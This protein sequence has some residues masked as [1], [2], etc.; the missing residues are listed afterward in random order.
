M[1]K[2]TL[3]FFGIILALLVTACDNGDDN[4]GKFIAYY[5]GHQYTEVEGWTIVGSLKSE[6]D[7]WVGFERDFSTSAP[8]N[9]KVMIHKGDPKNIFISYDNK[10]SGVTIFHRDTEPLPKYFSESI[11]SVVLFG[12]ADH[13]NIVLNG[14]IVK[15]MHKLLRDCR[16]DP[17]SLEIEKPKETN[18]AGIKIYFKNCNAYYYFGVL[19]VSETGK[20][21]IYSTDITELDPYSQYIALPVEIENYILAQVEL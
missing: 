6:E 10:I 18:I 16:E 14:T 9:S 4:P 7:A 5:Q 3:L 13:E 2:Y 12:F 11:S 21:C 17:E 1:R 19:G 15:E 20:L 8:N